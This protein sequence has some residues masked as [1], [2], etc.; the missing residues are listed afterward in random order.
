MPRISSGH[1][2]RPDLKCRK[3][4]TSLQR[5]RRGLYCSECD[6]LWLLPT[7]VIAKGNRRFIYRRVSTLE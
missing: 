6:Y 7:D 2:P 1:G 4:G 3:C 5:H